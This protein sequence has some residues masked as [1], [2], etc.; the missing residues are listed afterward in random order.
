[1]ETLR[2]LVARQD[3]AVISY[4]QEN[5]LLRNELLKTGQALTEKRRECDRLLI[6]KTHR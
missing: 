4:G 3:K 6:E 1:M 5:T 2:S